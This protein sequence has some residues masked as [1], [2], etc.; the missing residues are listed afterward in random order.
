M[1][2]FGQ[3]LPAPQV[4][5]E[6]PRPE[7]RRKAAAFA[8]QNGGERVP[9]KEEVDGR[10]CLWCARSYPLGPKRRREYTKEGEW[11]FGEDA[12]TSLAEEGTD[13]ATELPESFKNVQSHLRLDRLL[14]DD[15]ARRDLRVRKRVRACGHVFRRV[16]ERLGFDKAD[17]ARAAARGK[18]IVQSVYDSKEALGISIAKSPRVVCAGVVR[19]LMPGRE[20]PV[21]DVLEHL[22]LDETAMWWGSSSRNPRDALHAERFVRTLKLHF[23]ALLPH[24]MST[25]MRATSTSY[26]QRLHGRM[27]HHLPP[28]LVTPRALADAVR[29]VLEQAHTREIWMDGRANRLYGMMACLHVFEC[30]RFEAAVDRARLEAMTTEG[31]PDLFS[32]EGVLAWARWVS[33]CKNPRGEIEAVLA[34]ARK[35]HGCRQSP[36]D[37]LP[38]REAPEVPGAGRRKRARVR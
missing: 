7:C 22:Y 31:S 4:D 24:S 6:C 15:D 9:L 30:P 23:R 26:P 3:P 2:L 17:A 18:E 13:F 34:I 27:L 10:V 19:V 12:Y 37:D 32:E 5:G 11:Y 25:T 20:V 33:S 14:R 29:T 16:F 8:A 38:P 36:N 21:A 1:A 28:K 35:R